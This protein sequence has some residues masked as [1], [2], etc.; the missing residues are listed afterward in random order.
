MISNLHVNDFRVMIVKWR[1]IKL[2][3]T[4]NKDIEELK[5]K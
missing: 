3:E 2:Q 4:F 5:I 1:S